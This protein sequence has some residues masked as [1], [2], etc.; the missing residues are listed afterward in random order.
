M[1]MRLLAAIIIYRPVTE[2]LKEFEKAET[3]VV[4]IAKEI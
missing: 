1:R 2:F 3:N 4:A